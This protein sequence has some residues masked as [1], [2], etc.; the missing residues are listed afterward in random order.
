MPLR[1]LFKSWD[2]K[3]RMPSLGPNQILV[4]A[5]TSDLAVQNAFANLRSFFSDGDWL[6]PNN[7]YRVD[8]TNRIESDCN[9]SSINHTDLSQYIAAS[10]LLHCNDGWNYLSRAL[11]SHMRCDPA[12]ARHLAYY[13][14][15][16]AAMSLLATVGIGIFNKQHFVLYGNGVCHKINGTTHEMVWKCLESWADHSMLSS[17]FLVAELIQVNGRTLND[18]L[19]AFSQGGNPNIIAKKWLKTWGLDIQRLSADHDSRNEASYRPSRLNFVSPLNVLD[20][21]KFVHNL[22]SICEPSGSAGFSYIDRHILRLSLEML[23][24][25]ITGDPPSNNH[26]GF[27]ERIT[28]M[29]TSI[30]DTSIATNSLL[31][32][33][34]TRRSEPNNP[35]VF[36]E[37]H[38]QSNTNDPRHHLQVISRASLL[39][40]V[41]TA[42]CSYMIQSANVT[43]NDLNFWWQPMGEERGLWTSENLPENLTDLWEDI[44]IEIEKIKNWENENSTGASYEQWHRDCYPSSSML[45]CCEMIGLWGLG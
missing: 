17:S 38:K 21:S 16:R 5:G 26:H 3:K 8:T 34:L 12:S 4:L 7:C 36:D 44:N 14:E 2:I 22:W 20:T 11:S 39:L 37:A 9:N 23:F 45:S 1:K 35:I 32:N 19:N 6:A 41:A 18:W 10:T 43:I 13:A 30:G 33:F 27:E 15:L 42:S 29:F 24:E 40:R 25:A 31:K 28:R